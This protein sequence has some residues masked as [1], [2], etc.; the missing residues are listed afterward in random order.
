MTLSQCT[1][2][3]TTRSRTQGI[4]GVHGGCWKAEARPAGAGKQHTIISC[5][6]GPAPRW[7]FCV[8]WG[9]DRFFST[10]LFESPAETELS[11]FISPPH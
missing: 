9:F 4:A 8:G 3:T 1:A 10:A 7:K 6:G 11:E 5:C 2:Y